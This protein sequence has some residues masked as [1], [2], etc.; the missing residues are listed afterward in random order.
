MQSIKWDFFIIKQELHKRYNTAAINRQSFYF[1][2]VKNLKVY[3]IKWHKTNP[4]KKNT[5]FCWFVLQKI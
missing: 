2:Y 1:Y 3:I 5:Y 4:R